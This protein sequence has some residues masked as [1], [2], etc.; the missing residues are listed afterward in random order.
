MAACSEGPSIESASALGIARQ[1]VIS[2][3]PDSAFSPYR[4]GGVNAFDVPGD[5]VPSTPERDLVGDT[6]YPAF[7]RAADTDHVFFRLRIDG[8]PRAQNGV[9]LLPSSW[10]VLV[11]QDNN[12]QAY[13]YMLTADGNLGGTKVRWVRNSRKEP[14]NP[15]DPAGEEAADMLQDF[16]PASDY[17]NVKITTDGSNFNGNAD[18]WVTLVLPKT[19]LKVAQI[20]TAA[21]IV[22]WGGTNARNYSLNA[23]FGCSAGIPSNLADAAPE[24]SRLDLAGT[25]SASPDTATT[26]EDTAVRMEVL[27]NDQ[28]LRDT[29]LTID[30]V[31]PSPN[32]AAAV[33]ADH[34]VIFTPSPNFNG[35]TTYKY[36]VKDKD[37]ETAEAVVTV[38]VT[39]VNDPPT[40][41]DD[42]FTVPG[43]R[44]SLLRVLT[45]DSSEPDSGE[46]LTVSKVTQPTSGTVSISTDRT[47]VVFTPAPD[48][49]GTVTFTYTVSDGTEDSTPVTVTVTV[50]P[51]DSDGDGLTDD[52]EL[53]RG[54]D[55][56]KWDTDGGGMSDGDE[57]NAG[58][59]PL[60]YA[61]DLATGGRG[62]A[63]TGTSTLLPLALLLALTL[64]RRR[65][66]LRGSEK[67]WSVLGLLAALLV[68]APARAQNADQASQG[69]DVQQFKP[70]PGGKDVL[71]VQSPQVGRHLDWNLGLSFSYARDP[72]NFR[73]PLT[74]E[75][76][77]E[78]VKHQ[79]TVDLMGAVSL[80][81]Q[82]EL[83]MVVP[84]T[85]QNSAP[86][87][88]VA[89]VLGDGIHAEGMG[90]LRLVPKAH[91]RSFDNGLQLGVTVP[92]LLPTSGGKGFMGRRG[93][94][95]FPRL[96]GEWTHVN[97]ARVLVHLGINVQ[98]RAQ[99]YNL[100]V[101][102][103]FAYG[104][105]TEV[106]FL[107]GPHRL[108]AEATLVGAR[109]LNEWDL[110]E[111]PLELLAA[112]K[113]RFTDSL[114]AHL[115]SG[116][117]LTRGYGTPGFRLLAAIMWTEKAEAASARSKSRP[118]SEEYPQEPEDRGGF[119]KDWGFQS[120]A[121]PV[122]P[123]AD[124]DGDGILDATDHCPNQPETLNEFEDTDGCPDELPRPRRVDLDGD[125]ITDDQDRCPQFPEDKD[126]FQ[127]EDGCPDP[128]NDNDGVRDAVDRC[129]TEPET[130]NGFK[131]EDGCPDE[132]PPKG[133]HGSSK[134]LP[135]GPARA[136]LR[137]STAS[138]A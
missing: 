131:D 55:P 31:T 46:T 98:P 25:P 64:L 1:A 21:N 39:P 128:D 95:F 14:G 104:L 27:I 78:I 23:D 63:S 41:R 119:L 61:D 137:P 66:A 136:G 114:A 86:A 3:P 111:R 93:V 56:G 72:F 53:R 117:G 83:G 79:T 29:P 115:G 125:G 87:F 43:N 15:S 122:D 120:G 50:G 45:N 28:G 17:Y 68:S 35:T 22:V 57:V 105:G 12:P 82:F 138:R 26:P 84:F 69:I 80:Y 24:A 97:G 65:Q 132:V 75:F 13:E 89:P 73:Q 40:G 77:Y 9:D 110:E 32:G 96:L 6:T 71:G 91:L 109:G 11:D 130:R 76:I 59:N 135:G 124:T 118:S 67:H 116:M 5:A 44:A 34:A 36:R 20:S 47:H 48:F 133:R 2:I 112:L 90:D 10:D 62:C 85:T 108:A 103:E 7:F 70:G 88:S 18:Y 101:S 100:N 8:D 33:N 94:A 121:R 113:Y 30:I 126:G 60:N 102:N 99:F 129:P 52:E 16:T 54:T 127:D 107:V 81:D 51:G 4:C 106:P 38:K 19:A 49:E 58:R 42:T 123:N 134:P 37:G 74:G 92:V